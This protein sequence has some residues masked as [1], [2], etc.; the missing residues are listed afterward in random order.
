MDVTGNLLEV[1]LV[2]GEISVVDD[3]RSRVDEARGLRRFDPR[4][5][6][7]DRAGAADP[8]HSWPENLTGGARLVA[9]REHFIAV[10][11][12]GTGRGRFLVWNAGTCCG[13]AP[14]QG[15]DDV[16]F[17]RAMI[18]DLAKRTPI[19]RTRIY[20]TGL[21]NGA[22]MTYRIAAEAPDLVARPGDRLP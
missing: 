17:V 18:D 15:I 8:E 9:D 6:I 10:Y 16:G 12:N 14:L 5:V 2:G 3:Q 20:A 1:I 22:M 21:S 19:D 13:R 11:P 4:R 7:L